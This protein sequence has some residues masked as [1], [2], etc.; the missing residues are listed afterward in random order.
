MSDAIKGLQ[1]LSNVLGDS[2]MYGNYHDYELHYYQI[3]I[4]MIKH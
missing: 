3:R 2:C 1:I 4:F